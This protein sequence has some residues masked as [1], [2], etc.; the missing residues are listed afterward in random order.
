MMGDVKMKFKF[1]APARRSGRT[2]GPLVA[3]QDVDLR[4]DRYAADLVQTLETARASARWRSLAAHTLAILL[5]AP[6]AS[7]IA[8]PST[9]PATLPPIATSPAPAARSTLVPTPFRPWLPSVRATVQPRTT[10]SDGQ[11]RL[12]PRPA[13]DLPPLAEAT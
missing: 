7:V 12:R 5:V 10:S 8:A 1:I 9:Q 13:L 11:H 2:E 6:L 3:G 4:S